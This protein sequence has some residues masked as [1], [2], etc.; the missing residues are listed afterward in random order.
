MG[1]ADL[2]LQNNAAVGVSLDSSQLIEEPPKRL[3]LIARIAIVVSNILFVGASAFHIALVPK[4]FVVVGFYG[5]IGAAVGG[6]L[7]G[8]GIGFVL[9]AL[10]QP[11][12]QPIPVSRAQLIPPPPAQPSPPLSQS[13]TTLAV[14]NAVLSAEMLSQF[15]DCRADAK[16][17]AD[18][19]KG[20]FENCFKTVLAEM[21][22]SEIAA[23]TSLD[24]DKDCFDIN[25]LRNK[26]PGFLFKWLIKHL[27]YRREEPIEDRIAH[28]FDILV[29]IIFAP[30]GGFT[31][32]ERAQ[33]TLSIIELLRTHYNEPEQFYLCYHF[34]TNVFSTL[35]SFLDNVP[36][37]FLALS[38]DESHSK[39]AEI[40]FALNIAAALA[41]RSNYEKELEE[42]DGLNDAL[43]NAVMGHDYIANI[44]NDLKIL[45]L[46]YLLQH[47]EKNRWEAFKKNLEDTEF[48]IEAYDVIAMDENLR[49]KL[50]YMLPADCQE[51]YQ[52]KISAQSAAGSPQSVQSSPQNVQSSPQSVHDENE[53]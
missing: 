14:V 24:K 3:S 20:S 28:F 8:A 2:V 13:S 51:A 38:S 42:L 48:A 44:P 46:K 47:V 7:I 37:Y 30:Q 6:A 25:S 12:S 35:N 17:V 34:M 10:L 36:A 26:D 45:L 9:I 31:I 23:Y 19:F 16:A 43:F 15:K 5:T 21:E 32:P 27:G 40:F 49:A 53:I 39:D 4:I 1:G 41:K 33:A 52:E 50:W 29:P 18:L 11:R 22:H